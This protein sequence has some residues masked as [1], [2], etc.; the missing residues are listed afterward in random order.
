MEV[1]ADTQ[2]A[3][4]EQIMQYILRQ[5]QLNNTFSLNFVVGFS[6]S[7][8][9]Y[10]ILICLINFLDKVK[11]SSAI[12]EGSNVNYIKMFIFYTNRYKTISDHI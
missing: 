4:V 12:I 10:L 1:F 8:F 9:R 6:K 11:C 5:V 7:R 2:R 3:S